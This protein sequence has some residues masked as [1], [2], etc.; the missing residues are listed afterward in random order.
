MK[1]LILSISL[2]V[3]AWISVEYMLLPRGDEF[4]TTNPTETSVMEQRMEE[5][6]SSF[7]MR[8]LFVPINRISPNL[9][10][11]V[12]VAEDASFY[13]HNGFDWKSIKDAVYVAWRRKKFPRG[14]ST[15]SQQVSKNLYFSLS[16]DPLRKLREAVMTLRLERH[17]GKTRILELYL[18]I[19]EWGDGIFGAEAASKYYFNKSASSLTKYEAAILAAMLPSPRKIYNYKKNPARVQNRAAIILARM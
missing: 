7:T 10:R 9:R 4:L 3:L 14:A 15:I 2:L 12:V 8:Y 13:D 1:S 18:N 17:L 6:Q 5:A 19:A 11:A 16:R